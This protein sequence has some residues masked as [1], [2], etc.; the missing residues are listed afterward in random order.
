MSGSNTLGRRDFL[1]QSLAAAGAAGMMGLTK[2]AAGASAPPAAPIAMDRDPATSMPCGGLGSAKISRLLGGNLIGGYMHSRDLKYVNSLFRAYATEEKILETLALA[3]GHGINTLFETGGDFV[4]RYNKERGGRMQFIPHIEIRTNW[5]RTEQ[6][7]HIK[8]QVDT[9]GVALYVWGVSS[10][11]LAR[12]GQMHVLARAVE[13]AKKHGLPVGVGCHS[14]QVPMRCEKL[15]VPCDFYV[16]T[17]HSDDYF[18]ATPRELRKH[19]IWLDG[20]KGW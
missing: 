7:D 19:F 2:E 5:N 20:G 18:S 10:D 13:L 12:D 1:N 17:L 9:G 15:G 8:Q 11:P 3:E 4:Q 14:L 16:K 6:A